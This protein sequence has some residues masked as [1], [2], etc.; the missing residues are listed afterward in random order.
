MAPEVTLFTLTG[1]DPY[2]TLWKGRAAIIGDVA[3]PMA[4]TH[5]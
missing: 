5:A 1:R 3:H 2:D 4:P